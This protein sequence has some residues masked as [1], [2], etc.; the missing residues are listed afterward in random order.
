MR[1]QHGRHQRRSIRLKDYDYSQP[2]AYFITVRTVNLE[3]IFGRISNGAMRLNMYGKIVRKCWDDLPNHYLNVKL[4]VF[5]IMPD[6]VHGIIFIENDPDYYVGAGFKPA[7]TKETKPKKHGLP[8]IIR[9]FKT[10]SSRRINKRRNTVGSPVWQR[11]FYD[12]VIRNE[13]DLNRIRDYIINNP[14]RWHLDKYNPNY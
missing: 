9:A 1:R 10:F 11:G 5:V 12:H 4:D 6:H 8:E 2:G 7:P 13:Q 14:L 3:C